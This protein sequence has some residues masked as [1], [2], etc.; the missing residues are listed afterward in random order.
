MLKPWL[1][2]ML[3]PFQAVPHCIEESKNNDKDE[4]QGFFAVLRMRTSIPIKKWL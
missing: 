3:K 1:T 4:I 2:Q